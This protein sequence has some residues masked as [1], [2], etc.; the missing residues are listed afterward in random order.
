[1]AKSEEY[2]YGALD[3]LAP[4]LHTPQTKAEDLDEDEYVLRYGPPFGPCGHPCACEQCQAFRTRLRESGPVKP[5]PKITKDDFD[6]AIEEVI[7]KE[8]R[9]EWRETI[10]GQRCFARCWHDEEDETYCTE[11]DCDLRDLCE[12][13]WELVRGGLLERTDSES[14]DSPAQTRKI[15]TR[16]KRDGVL[17]RPP[18]IPKG[19]WKGTGKYER[20]PYLDQNRPIDRVAHVLWEF[21][22]SPP[23]LP[24]DW[25]YAISKTKEQEE[26]ARSEFVA[27]FGTGVHVV[28][29]AS[30]HQYI[31]NGY[32]LL[33]IWVNGAGGGWVDCATALS[34]ALLSDSKNM[35]ER[36]PISGRKTK[37]RF[38]P[39]RV[40][41]AKPA[42]IERFKI[43]L[44]TLPEL[45]YLSRD[46]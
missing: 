8:P 11:M 16:I 33:R 41:L 45:R 39:Y 7:A 2:P 29:R 12:T 40:F 23:A 31:C 27:I 9:E 37:F 34:K 43:A 25:S 19:K 36:T 26:R 15:G 42:S 28:R 14:I 21:L 4:I 22:G 1:M 32:H 44:T 10:R 5:I 24:A 35:I 6:K 18:K 38:Y 46:R 13:T 3:D 30:Y 20:V 17:R